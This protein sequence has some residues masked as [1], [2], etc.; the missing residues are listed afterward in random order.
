MPTDRPYSEEVADFLCDMC[1][2][3]TLS[4]TVLSGDGWS[5]LLGLAQAGL[6]CVKCCPLSNRAAEQLVEVSETIRIAM[7]VITI[8]LS[9]LLDKTDAVCFHFSKGSSDMMLDPIGVI[10]QT[11]TVLATANL[12]LTAALCNLLGSNTRCET[13][14]YWQLEGLTLARVDVVWHTTNPGQAELFSPGTRQ[15]PSRPLGAFLEP[16][17]SLTEWRL[18][19]KDENVIPCWSPISNEAA[20]YPWPL[21]HAPLWVQTT[22]VFFKDGSLVRCPLS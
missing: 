21:T 7:E 17:A 11:L 14:H 22:S 12:S 6:T 20:P 8:P 10:P 15:N 3:R 13:L 2:L 9:Q 18:L 16:S 4:V 1:V 5:W 19:K